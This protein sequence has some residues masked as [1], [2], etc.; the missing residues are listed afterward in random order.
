[1]FSKMPQKRKELFVSTP[2]SSNDSFDLENPE[3]YAR[4]R[5]AKLDGYPE[6]AEDLVVDIADFDNPSDAEIAALKERVRKTNMAVY[7]TGS[8]KYR[9][10]ASA[11]KAIDALG[12]Q[13]GL[14]RRDA[15]LCADEDAISPL[16][17]AEGGHRGRYIPYTNRAISWHTDGYYNKLKYQIRGMVLHCVS[18]SASGGENALMDQDIAYIC[19]R[20]ENP[21]F[22][23]ALM[24]P[25]AMLIPANDEGNG[26][27]R[28]AQSG[29]VFSIDGANK[30][31]H[32]RYTAR[33]RSIEWRDDA[34]T[35]AAV[36]FLSDLLNSDSPY[37]FKHRMAAGDGVLCNNVLHNRSAFEDEDNCKRLFLRA[38]Y[39]DRISAE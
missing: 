35:A 1:M 12:R 7:S 3:A 20:D 10:S 36:A 22:I 31:L 16:S 33:T 2:Y 39:F 9:D 4:W 13:F 15:N 25:D 26:V 6:K 24:H 8:N 18:P 17:V 30:A 32:M 21:D 14:L 11:K 27:I 5:Q 38:R 29:P 23:R 28:P 37:K 19:L 34:T